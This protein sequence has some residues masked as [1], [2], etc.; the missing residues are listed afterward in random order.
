MPTYPFPTD[1]D[2]EFAD[3]AGR[4]FDTS[5][6]G[7]EPVSVRFGAKTVDIPPPRYRLMS[8]GLSCDGY[9]YTP[10]MPNQSA[11]ATNVD[12]AIGMKRPRGRPIAKPPAAPIPDSPEYI[13][14][15]ILRAPR[16]RD[17]DWKYPRRDTA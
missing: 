10:S 14:R 17:G 9:G 12:A 2:A 16:R 8:I 13:A 7:P 6:G 1:Q 4:I 3:R 5:I 11:Q 15:A